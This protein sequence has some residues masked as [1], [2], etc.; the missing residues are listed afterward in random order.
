MENLVAINILAENDVVRNDQVSELDIAVEIAAGEEKEREML[1]QEL[2][3]CIVIDR[4][5]SMA[6]EKLETAKRSCIEIYNKLRKDDLFIV[7]VFDD[8]AEVIVNPQSEKK[9]IIGK[10]Q[11][12]STGGETNLSLGWYL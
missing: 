9:E 6:G 1:K 7:V 12:I 11:G 4:S 2:S 5:G 10:I 3:L 8:E